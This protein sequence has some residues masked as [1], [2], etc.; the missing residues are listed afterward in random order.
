MVGYLRT[1]TKSWL[2]NVYKGRGNVLACGSYRGIK[3]VKQAML[4]LGRL[5]EGLRRFKVEIQ[6]GFM[7]GR[8]MPEVFWWR[9]RR[10]GGSES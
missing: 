2:V 10:G 3:L 1:W 5:I 4:V 8:S 9:R 6:F 7:A